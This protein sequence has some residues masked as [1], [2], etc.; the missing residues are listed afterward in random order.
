M[1]K[2]TTKIK[3]IPFELHQVPHEESS[4]RFFFFKFIPLAYSKVGHILS[5]TVKTRAIH[6]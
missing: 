2:A 4:A 1:I 6:E 3:L 5:Y